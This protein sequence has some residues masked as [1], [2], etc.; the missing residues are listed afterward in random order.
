M[1]F[2]VYKRRIMNIFGLAIWFLKGVF[3]IRSAN[4]FPKTVPEN[5]A[6]Y[7][8]SEMSPVLKAEN[9]VY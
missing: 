7:S 5:T 3:K 4:T 9:I 1:K 6:N 8:K 2:M